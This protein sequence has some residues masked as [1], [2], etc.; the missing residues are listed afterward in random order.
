MKIL[1]QF[2]ALLFMIVILS[3]CNVNKKES[4]VK[5]I[6]FWTL[7]L[8]SFAPYI[9]NIISKYEKQHP[10]V[11]IKWI[12]VP[13]TEGEKRALASIMSKKVPD[14]INLNPDFASTLASRGALL[15][16]NKELSPENKKTYLPQSW[17]YSQI[18]GNIFGIPWYISTSVTF[19]NKEIFKKS[20]INVENVPQNYDNI[21]DFSKKIDENTGKYAFMPTLCE[22]GYMLKVFN[23]NDSLEFNDNK[24]SIN[25]KTNNETLKL[26]KKLYT[27]K[28]IPAESITLG[29]RAAL[30]KFMS[31]ET[32]FIVSGGNFAKIIKENSPLVYKNLGVTSQITGSNQKYDFSLMNLVIP[33]KSNYPK[34]A[35]D[36]ALFLTNP[37]NQ[38]EFCKLAPILP[39]AQKTLKSSFFTEEKNDLIS[40]TRII[41]AKQLNNAANPVPPMQNKSEINGVIDSMVQYAI[42][43]KKPTNKALSDAEKSINQI[44]KEN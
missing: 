35:L 6:E 44:L 21:Y 42:L 13:F 22:N 38:L 40:K 9:Q 26:F 8:K 17:K 32:S 20:G 2:I 4:N 33:L 30:E 28:L 36:F 5:E 10:D 41:S 39:S 18:N 24:I 25:N 3:G 34:E 19:Y 15:N 27:Q 16:L 29:H 11:K 7:Q 1:K 31:G 43:G 23:L 12:D 37:Q 14:L